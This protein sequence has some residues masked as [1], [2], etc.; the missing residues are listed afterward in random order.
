MELRKEL[1][2]RVKKHREKGK[3]AY[4]HYRAIVFKRRNNQLSLSRQWFFLK[5]EYMQNDSRH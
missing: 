5:I 1:W 3:I 2:E 4:F